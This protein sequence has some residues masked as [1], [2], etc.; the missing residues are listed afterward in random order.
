MV[1]RAKTVKDQGFR[2]RS[3]RF[4]WRR[5]V[6]T[7]HPEDCPGPAFSRTR[8]RDRICCLPVACVRSSGSAVRMSASSKPRNTPMAGS[9][10]AVF[11]RLTTTSSSCTSNAI[12]P[13]LSRARSWQTDL[14]CRP[15]FGSRQG[16]DGRSTRMESLK[17]EIHD[18][19]C[20]EAGTSS[21]LSMYEMI[22][23]LS[24]ESPR[25]SR[26]LRLSQKWIGGEPLMRPCLIH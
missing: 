19:G 17:Y 2:T 6:H 18:A 12:L 16:A 5:P 21:M 24:G 20:S 9:S 22:F 25:R 13:Q 4:V 15:P 3:S 10:W 23:L 1:L 7:S 26:S 14:A 8:H 11:T